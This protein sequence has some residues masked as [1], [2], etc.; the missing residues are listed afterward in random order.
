MSLCFQAIN[1]YHLPEGESLIHSL[2]HASSFSQ[3]LTS[4][5]Q[6]APLSNGT[7]Q[8]PTKKASKPGNCPPTR[9]VPYP[10]ASRTSQAYRKEITTHP[11]NPIS[12]WL[13]NVVRRETQHHRSPPHL[14]TWNR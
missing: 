2:N 7:S 9:G 3:E 8:R 14:I 12:W 6:L 5:L 4:H 13:I 1:R 10:N 11:L